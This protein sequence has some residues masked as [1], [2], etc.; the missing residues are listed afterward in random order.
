MSRIEDQIVAWLWNL[1][2]QTN[3][4]DPHVLLRMP[5]TKVN[6]ILVMLITE[7]KK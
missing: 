7:K 3:G 5:M 4:S 1:F 6:E 2:I